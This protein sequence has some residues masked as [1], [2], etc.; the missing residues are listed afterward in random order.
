MPRNI[1]WAADFHAY[2]LAQLRLRMRARGV[3]SRRAT[4]SCC[5]DLIIIQLLRSAHVPPTLGRLRDFHH[6]ILQTARTG[7]CPS[8]GYGAARRPSVRGSQHYPW[9][10]RPI[11]WLPKRPG[12]P[13]SHFK[14]S[15]AALSSTAQKKQV[16]IKHF[17]SK[18]AA[19]KSLSSVCQYMCMHNY[20][21][22][23]F[24]TQRYQMTLVF[25]Q[26]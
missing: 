21:L 20:F 10:I 16:V 2:V 4:S 9:L 19:H 14:S 15:G 24:R 25:A 8:P 1:C 11:L 13:S 22:F 23:T 5:V 7:F 17:I 12:D 6:L 26:D 18:T 3:P